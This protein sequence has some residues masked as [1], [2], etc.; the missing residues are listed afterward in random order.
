MQP[1]VE[2]VKVQ[3]GPEMERVARQIAAQRGLERRTKRGH[4][5]GCSPVGPSIGLYDDR[6]LEVVRVTTT[7]YR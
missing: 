4:G 1:V 2:I 7:T 5:S 3:T 6:G